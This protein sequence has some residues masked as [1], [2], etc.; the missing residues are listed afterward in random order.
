MKEED[1]ASK[2][3]YFGEDSIGKQIIVE[4]I[5][6]KSLKRENLLF[7]KGKNKVQS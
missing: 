4:I 2:K 6:K 7:F 1:E 5:K 3:F